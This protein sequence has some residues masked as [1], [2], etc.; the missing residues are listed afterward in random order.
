[1]QLS[2]SPLIPPRVDALPMYDLRSRGAPIGTYA[3]RV[4]RLIVNGQIVQLNR[5]AVAVIDTGTTGLTVS[6]SA[7]EMLPLPVREARIELVTESGRTVA[8][9]VSSFHALLCVYSNCGV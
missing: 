8:I 3:C 1:M 4:K 5:P 9:E 7:F 6:D 2:P